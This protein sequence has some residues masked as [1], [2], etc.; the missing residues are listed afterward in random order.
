MIHPAKVNIKNHHLKGNE[1]IKVSKKLS[2]IA[3]IFLQQESSRA[4]EIIYEVEAYFPVEEETE[5]GLFFGITHL[6]AGKIGNEYFMTKG[7]FHKQLNR[8]EFYWGL[9][10]EG[11][12][13]LM[14][15][16][17]KCKAEEMKVGSLHYIAGYIA[18]RVVNT[19]SEILSFG[20]SWPSDAGH[21]YDTIIKA[22]FSY[23]LVEENGKPTIKE[24]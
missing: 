12:L 4:N 18:H 15:K 10:G 16:E 3:S 14:D 8:G 5:G 24:A 1:V 11:V 17:G 22:G 23:R 19:G 7:H 6:Q 20:A 13:L 2:D 9:K 21:D